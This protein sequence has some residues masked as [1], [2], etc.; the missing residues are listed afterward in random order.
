MGII[1]KQSIQSTILTYIGVAIGFVN[2]AILLPRFFTTEQVGLFGFLN[3]LSSIVATLATFGIPLITIKMFPH[4]RSEEKKHNGFFSLTVIA[5]IIGITSGLIFF[6]LFKNQLISEKNAANSYAYFS[7]LFCIV[8]ASR[9]I[10]R[11]FDSYVRMLYKTVLGTLLEGVGVK[12]FVFAAL[13]SWVLLSYKFDF[14]F[15]AYALALASAGIILLLYIPRLKLSLNYKQFKAKLGDRRKELYTV[16]FFGIVGSLGTIIVLE[17]D[18]IMVSNMIG[19]DANGIYSVAFFFGLFVSVPAR[20]LRRIATVIISDSWKE[21]KLDNINSIYKKS[22]INQLLISGYLFLGIWFCIDYMFDFMQ[23]EYTNG[24]YVIL[25]IGLAQIV[26]MIT[27]VNGEIIITSKYYKYN[28]YFIGG[29]ILGVVGLNYLFIPIWG[30][31]GAALASLIAMIIINA[32]RFIFL[33][34]KFKF[35]PFT[36]NIVINIV[37]MLVV[38]GLMMLVPTVHNS[39][40]GILISGTILTLIYWVPAYFLNISDDINTSIDKVIAKYLKRS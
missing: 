23:P 8:F 10:F 15:M 26:D 37:L 2:S 27:G 19:L 29:L 14:V 35:Q 5:S 9:V 30:I 6:L 12:L 28:T 25:F 17:V 13:I 18:R 21:N 38:Y 36:R 34:H 1:K 20:G 24:K 4:F 7:I 11:N 31:N 16:G 40:L 33:Y 32:L 3:S 22:C 39:I